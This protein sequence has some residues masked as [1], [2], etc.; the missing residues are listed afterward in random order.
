MQVQLSAPSGGRHL[1][2]LVVL[3]GA[4]A[5][6]TSAVGG[7]DQVADCA[8]VCERYQ[9]CFD[10]E[11]D[12]DSCKTRCNDN[13]SDPEFRAHTNSCDACINVRDC[14]DT[15]FACASDCGDVIGQ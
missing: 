4:L 15:V 7:C 10:A 2:A 12:V 5:G 1:L 9:S 6:L 8:S 11:Y 14:A 13:A 3:V